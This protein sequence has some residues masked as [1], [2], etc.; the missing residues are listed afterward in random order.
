M[1]VDSASD[2]VFIRTNSF[3]PAEDRLASQ[4]ANVFGVGNVVICADE[5]RG[6]LDTGNWLRCSLSAQRAAEI[7][8]VP[9]PLDWGWRMGDLCHIAVY[10][11]FGLRPNQWLVEND[12]FIPEGHETQVFAQLS[13]IDA[14]FMAC[15]LRPKKIKPIAAG[16]RLFLPDADWGCIFAFNRLSG[17]RVPELIATRQSIA[18][19]LS[20][21]RYKT[22]NDEAVMA[23]L[24]HYSGWTHVDLYNA[25]P[26]LFSKLWFDTNP[27]MLFEGLMARSDDRPRVVH[28]V[29]TFEQL[30][31]RMQAANGDGHPQAYGYN[32]L[33]RILPAL[34]SQQREQIL[35]L[36]P[37]RPTAVN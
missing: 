23:N 27:P 21:S 33:S 3:G 8:G 32:R 1:S 15:N 20:G 29:L 31:R 34:K 22:P 7:V 24:A 19:K 26:D 6:A 36:L 35:A 25:A 18:A 16:V 4:L 12:I 28:P 37:D 11:D 17:A 13:A 2:L 14:D 5:T 9:V 10:Q 30:Y